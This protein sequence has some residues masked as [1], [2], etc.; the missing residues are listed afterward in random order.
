[1]LVVMMGGAR[2]RV[3]LLLLCVALAAVASP[4]ASALPA[5]PTPGVTYQAPTG[6]TDP[7]PGLHFPYC[8][9]REIPVH[10]ATLYQ[11]LKNLE[12]KLE[13]SRLA[14]F[15]GK[16][17]AF[18]LA[19]PALSRG[20]CAAIE[21]AAK[22]EHITNDSVLRDYLFRSAMMEWKYTSGI[23]GVLKGSS[24]RSKLTCQLQPLSPA[25]ISAWP[26]NGRPTWEYCCR[27][28][29]CVGD[30]KY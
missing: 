14:K 2:K 10:L 25:Q 3:M 9:P 28:D 12:T 15:R 4:V 22:P 30:L 17:S 11:M 7:G 1:M 6:V 20:S 8:R 5:T 13:P 23:Y 24:A 21:S 16:L 26:G 19:S 27:V 18:A 29:M